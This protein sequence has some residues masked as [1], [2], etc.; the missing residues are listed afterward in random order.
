MKG[1]TLRTTVAGVL[2]ASALALTGCATDAGPSGPSG[3]ATTSPPTASSTPTST[4]SPTQAAADPADVTTWTV[5][6]QGIGPARLGEAFSDVTAALP[7]WTVVPGCSWTA[8]LSSVDQQVSAYF[9]R[10]SDDAEGDVT[11]VT[12]EALADSVTPADGPRTAEGIGL[13]STRDEVMA[14]YP[15]AVSQK[16]TIADGELLRVRT[17]GSAAMYFE[18]REGATTVSA[19]TVTVRPEPPYEVCA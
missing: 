16:P 13:G 18:I 1:F 17:Q 5:S 19:V 10:N 9:A 4:P 11:T 14:A 8:A 2:V 12:F 6:A 3:T 15:A 7:A